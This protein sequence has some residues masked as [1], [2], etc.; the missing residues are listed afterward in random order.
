[1]ALTYSQPK[2][3]GTPAPDFCLPATDEQTYCLKDFAEAKVLVV[4]FACNHCPYSQ[5][6]RPRIIALHD[7]YDELGVQFCAINAND[8]AAYPEDSFVHMKEE[9]YNYPFPYLRDETQDI[10]HAFGA[11]CTPDIFVYDGERKLVYHGRVDDNWKN[12]EQVT[13]E[14]LRDALDDLLNGERPSEEQHPS[15]GC[16][17][18]WKNGPAQRGPQATGL[19]EK[20][21]D[22]L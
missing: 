10:T 8:E 15:M 11:V 5:A 13:Q 22:H 6:I 18:K 2:E 1:M 17:I 21:G 14:D 12:P 19:R 9:R 20:E 7:F 3:L 4:V 16:S